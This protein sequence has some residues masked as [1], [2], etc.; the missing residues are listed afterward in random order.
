MGIVEGMHFFQRVVDGRSYRVAAQSVWDPKKGQPVS[1]QVLLGPA[2]PAPVVDLGKTRTVGTRGF[3]DVGALAWVAEELD[4][5]RL[6][7]EACRSASVQTGPSLGE[8]TVAVAVQRACQPGAKRDLG[9]F[10][11][12]SVPRISCLP[13]DAFSG[14]AFYRAALTVTDEQVERAQVAIAK[15]AVER[16]GLSADVLAFDSPNFDTF[17]ATTTKG[18]LSKRGHAKS[19]RVDLRVRSEEHTSELQ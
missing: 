16:F 19:K 14:Q 17:I 18:D 2:E 9:D 4:V 1:R 8:Q 10:L 12:G 5:T 6:V 15:A 3:G 11:A 7:N 13:A